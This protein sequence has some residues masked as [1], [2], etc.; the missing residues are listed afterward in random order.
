MPMWVPI[1]CRFPS[2][3][4]YGG[5]ATGTLALVGQVV[6]SASLVTVAM[7]V[8]APLVF[9]GGFLGWRLAKKGELRAP[10][11]KFWAI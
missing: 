9:M 5:A 11:M 6:G 8:L 2:V 10:A 4:I 3:T 7:P 1:R